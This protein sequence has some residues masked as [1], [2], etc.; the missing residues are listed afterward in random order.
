MSAQVLNRRQGCCNLSLSCFNFII[1]Y[2]PGSQQRR[3]NTL[4]RRSYLIPKEG[5]AAYDQQHSIL[6]K[7]EEYF[8]KS[9]ILQ[10]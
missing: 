9:C 1:T 3:S 8:S 10:Q 2:R 5:D 7:P 6:L 4:S